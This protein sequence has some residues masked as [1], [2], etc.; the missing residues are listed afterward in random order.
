MAYSPPIIHPFPSNSEVSESVYCRDPP[1]VEDRF[2]AI[3]ASKDPVEPES[4]GIRASYHPQSPP[5]ISPRSEIRLRFLQPPQLLLPALTF[6]RVALEYGSRLR[7]DE[8]ERTACSSRRVC[9]RQIIR[10]ND[11]VN[12]RAMISLPASIRTVPYPT[13]AGIASRF[14]TGDRSSESRVRIDQSVLARVGSLSRP[15]TTCKQCA[16]TGRRPQFLSVV[17]A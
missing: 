13:H 5:Q 11:T 9:Y 2:L 15:V 7:Q 8:R 10:V 4:P 1:L 16:C 14:R 6:H 3:K 17:G 12:V